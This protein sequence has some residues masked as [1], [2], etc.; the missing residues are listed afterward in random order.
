MNAFD[1]DSDEVLGWATDRVARQ[2]LPLPKKPKDFG[3]E[4]SIPDDP[5][6]MESVELGQLIARFRSWIAYCVR[7]IGVTES[8]QV[9]LDDEWSLRMGA[10]MLDA[11]NELGSGAKKDMLTAWALRE[12]DDLGPLYLRR[13][14]LKAV[15]AQLEP[16]LKI[17]ERGY[18]ALSRELSRREIETRA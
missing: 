16:R 6:D 5:D 3:D 1:V 13:T 11:R 9:L 14:Q 2:N 12:S 18:R 15:M 4:Y 8:E 17:Y 7:L 10:A